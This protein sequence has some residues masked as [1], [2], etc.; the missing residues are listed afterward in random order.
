MTGGVGGPCLPPG[1]EDRRGE[2]RA[3]EGEYGKSPLYM[4]SIASATGH[5]NNKKKF[6][7]G[8]LLML[9]ENMT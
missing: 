3:G 4:G 8:L 1:L 2:T 9:E 5:L 7:M 6:F